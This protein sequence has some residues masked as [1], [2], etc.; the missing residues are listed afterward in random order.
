VVPDNRIELG[1]KRV[2]VIDDD[3]CVGT[4]IQIMLDR[5]GCDAVHAPDAAIA[6]KIFASFKFDLVIVDIFMPGING[7]EVIRGFRNL[8]AN[9]PI[10]A[11]SG[12][13]FRDT[14][15]PSTDF[16]GLAEAAG[17]AAGLRKP[18]S[19]AQLMTAVRAILGSEDADSR[20]VKIEIKN[21]DPYDGPGHSSIQ[22]S[23][24]S[25]SP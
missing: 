12:F 8:A 2:L 4:A 25:S 23:E 20:S 6:A 13:R 11:M 3:I 17:A 10:L 7:L 19:P 14:M 18:F 22:R 1:A 15:D 24:L 9:V 21:K 16:L 5:E